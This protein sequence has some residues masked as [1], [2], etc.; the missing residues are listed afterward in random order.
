[1]AGVHR[2]YPLRGVKEEVEKERERERE[3]DED[4]LE[5]GR[6]SRLERN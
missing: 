3:R 1:V 2:C 5:A 4:Q 6:L